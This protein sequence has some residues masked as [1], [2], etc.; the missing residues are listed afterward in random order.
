ML[1]SGVQFLRVLKGLYFLEGFRVD[2]TLWR[3]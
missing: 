1:Q 2:R 3:F